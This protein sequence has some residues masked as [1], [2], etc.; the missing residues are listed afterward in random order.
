[1][2]RG[3]SYAED[4]VRVFLLSLLVMAW[5]VVP[6]SAQDV[7]YVNGVSA[8]GTPKS[9][10]PDGL[11]LELGGATKVYPWTSLSPAT[12]FRYDPVYRV[13]LP[14][15]QA[16]L[17]AASRTNPPETGYLAASADAAG[18]PAAV[19]P[20]AVGGRLDLVAYEAVP[21]LPRASIPKLDVR[22]PEA[23]LSWG[24]RY[25]RRTNDV[26]YFVFDVKEPGELPESMVI[27]AA[28]QEQTDRIKA[29]RRS[30]GGDTQAQFRKLRYTGV[31][32]DAEASLDL[33]C[34]FSVRNPTVLQL[35]A[36]VELKRGAQACAFS[37]LGAPAGALQGNGDIAARELLTPPS[38]WLAVEKVAG[39]PTAV[40]NIRMGRFKLLP[41]RG[42]DPALAVTLL[43]E[44]GQPV[45]E[46]SVSLEKANLQDRYTIS[47]PLEKTQGGRTY[48][49][50]ASLDLGP[51]LGRVRYEESVGL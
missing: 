41:R 1:M 17:P 7:R 6:A 34:S 43:D 39:Q 29:A 50:K 28:A 36:E 31:F 3:L 26:A 47:V 32:G 2:R 10:S 42:M 37:L 22:N 21:P 12:R 18:A 51:M 35:A 38:L 40:G 44:A 48:K 23:A 46:R 16:G 15:V 25:G 27:H 24:I 11:E 19:S 9:A 14:A 5:V 49:L 30:E 13:N 4:M 8:R 45:M 20:G 33:S